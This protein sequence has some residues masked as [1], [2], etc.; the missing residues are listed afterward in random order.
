MKDD[1]IQILLITNNIDLYEAM[2]VILKNRYEIILDRTRVKGRVLQ[3]SASCILV[4]L[5]TIGGCSLKELREIVTSIEKPVIAI[6]DSNDILT[7]KEAMNIG[8]YDY[9]DVPL[10]PD[11]VVMSVTRAVSYERLRK[12]KREVRK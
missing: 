2:R 9:I 7:R 10:D 5:L 1:S 11:R 12:S 3:D 4:D 6:I 8:M